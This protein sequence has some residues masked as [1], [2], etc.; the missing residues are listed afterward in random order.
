MTFDAVAAGAVCAELQ[1][2]VGAKIMKIYQPDRNVLVFKYHLYTETRSENGK[3]LISSHPQNHRI[4]LTETAAEN[5]SSPPLFCMVLR[6]YL[7]GG[8]ISSVTQRP[9]ERIIDIGIDYVSEIG[10]RGQC[11]LTV[12]L[13]GKHSNIIL[14]DGEGFIID[15]V[16]RFSHNLSRHRQVL[17]REKYLPPPEQNKLEWTNLDEE[18]LGAALFVLP[19]ETFL[20]D[21]LTKA[22]CG[23]SPF[24]AR[25][26]LAQ[27]GIFPQTPLSEVGQFELTAVLRGLRRL[28]TMMLERDFSPAV[29]L[30]GG[31]VKDFY[32]FMPTLWQ[33]QE[34][35]SFDSVNEAIDCYYARREDE[36]TF[37][38]R[39]RELLK[40]VGANYARL[41]KKASLQQAD[42]THAQSAETYKQAGDLLAANLYSLERGLSSVTLD[43]FYDEGK[44]VE[45]TLDPVKTPEE[46]M[47]HYYRLYNKNKNA[48]K[49]IAEQLERSKEELFYLGGVLNAA[50]NTALNMEIEEIKDELREGGYLKERSSDKKARGKKAAG[51]EEKLPPLEFTSSDGFTVWVGRN[52]KQ[53]DILTLKKAAKNDLWLHTKDI[54]GSHVIIKTGGCEVPDTT[55]SEAAALAAGYSRAK[56]SSKVPVDY[57]QVSQVKKPAGAKPGRVIYFQQKTIMVEP[58]NGI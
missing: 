57:T 42:F 7:E 51:A 28:R 25:E 18:I 20:A 37:A 52:N 13:M 17:P 55:L 27:A 44:P 40:V 19:E 33:E 45:I 30:E 56:N 54:P 34:T 1:G 23:V 58:K 39:K 9:Y 6:K 31:A 32:P 15:A 46:N 12:E 3:L 50:E 5:P 38:D 35:L 8:R 11:L 14:V 53:N 47:R 43:N 4:H 2:L 22:L 41:D 21:A 26:L 49:L 36:N 48:L 16:R 10:D 29:R 24:F